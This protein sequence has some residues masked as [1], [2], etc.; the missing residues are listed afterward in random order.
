MRGFW[1][2]ILGLSG[3]AQASDVLYVDAARTSVPVVE[4]P[5]GLRV[6]GVL[7]GRTGNVALKANAQ[8]AAVIAAWPEVAYVEPHTPGI[9]LYEV[10]AG[11]GVDEIELSRRM[12]DVPG[13]V[14]AHPDFVVDLIPHRFDDPAIADSWYLDNTGRQGGVPGV[15]VGAFQAWEHATGL[16]QIIAIIDTGL[17]LTHEDLRI[18]EGADFLDKGTDASPDP[19]Y[20]GHG[21]G[22]AMAGVAAAIGGNGLGGAGIAPDASVLPVR[23]IG[24]GG[25]TFDI[26]DAFV[27]SVDQ[28]ASVLSNSWG[29]SAQNCPP[30][31]FFGLI[32]EA[33]TYAE[34]TGRG[35]RGAVVAMS[36]GNGGC[37]ASQDAWHQQP[38][39]V[40]VGA[41]SDLDRRISYSNFGQTLDVM[42]FAGG[43]G[44][45]GLW[46]TDVAGSLGYTGGSYWDGGSGTSSACASVAGV[47]ALMFEANPRLTAAQARQVLCDTAVKPAWDDAVWDE[48]GWSPNYGCGRVDAAAA[49]EAVRNRAPAVSGLFAGPIR[50]DGGYL[51]WTAEDPDGDRLSFQVEVTGPGGEVAMSLTT[52][53]TKVRLMDLPPG[54]PYA[55]TVAANDP[56][57]SPEP[58]VGPTFQVEPRPVPEEARACQAGAGPWWAAMAVALLVRRRR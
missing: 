33:L 45:P 18:L 56:W 57:G 44:R 23:L 37:D 3:P 26:H 27:W 48:E 49:V 36:L 21:H 17:D 22:T 8:A 34:E 31:P 14:F 4:G 29:F 20:D 51:T 42:G 43:D 13:V 41:A 32:G 38:L 50:E 55:W 12:I 30:V 19:T 25:T 47:L 11:P 15:D 58:V 54:G 53:E 39:I 7:V 10:V 1:W 28:G 2:L 46:T 24:R 9:D 5:D 35:G 16:G 52:A 40:S 6:G